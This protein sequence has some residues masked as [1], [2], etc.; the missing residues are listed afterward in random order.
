M[1]KTLTTFALVLA[2][3]CPALAGIM[4]TPPIAPEPEP[5]PT[6]TVQNSTATSEDTTGAADTLTQLVLTVLASILP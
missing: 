6:S 2:L 1:R 4:H 3:S 5:R